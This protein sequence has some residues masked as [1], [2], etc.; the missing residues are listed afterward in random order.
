MRNLKTVILILVIIGMLGVFA[1]WLYENIQ[2]SISLI[3][4]NGGEILQKDSVYTIKWETH[5]IPAENKISINIRRIASTSLPI[6]G[7]EFDPIIFIDLENTGNIDWVISDMYPEGDYI[8]EINSYESTP[9]IDVISDESD[10]VFKIIEFSTAQVAYICKEDKTIDAAFYRGEK[11]ISEPEG[12]PMPSGSVKISLSD[13]R[14]FNLSQTISASGVRYANSDESFI[15]WSKGNGALVLENNVEKSY[16]GC[17]ALARDPGGL[18]E[19]YLDSTAGFS[20]RYPTDYL[21]DVSY[22]YQGLGAGQ[23]ISGV[24]FTIPSDFVDGINLSSFDTGVSIEIIPAV[25]DC[26]AGLFLSNPIDIQTIID[27]D[28]QYSFVSTAEG[29][30]GNF[31]EEMIWAVPGTN[32]CIAV[33]Y[34]IH[35]TNIGHYPENAVKEFDRTNLIE[36]FDK[37]RHSLTVL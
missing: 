12:I 27:N 5:N 26:H 20:V 3:S 30:A 1:Y 7:Q 31:Y 24:K 10:A 17:I 9:I 15:F 35:S 29:A 16:I 2:P 22:Q 34:L 19:A 6:D 14:D 4:P 37:I 33:R 18:P 8:I 13:G 28:I 11:E 32:P 21:K 25:R 23:E 36:Q